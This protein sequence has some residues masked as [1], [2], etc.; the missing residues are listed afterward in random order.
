MPTREQSDDARPVEEV[1]PQV[2]S[3]EQVTDLAPARSLGVARGLCRLSD[4]GSGLYE[5]HPACIGQL[6]MTLRAIEEPRLQLP[7]EPPDL[8]TQGGLG[9]M[10]SGG[11][12]P[13][14]QLFGHREE[15]TQV[16]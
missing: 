3:H 7:L 2:T 14:V 5:E 13:E 15:V 12:T 10:E 4:E 8:L 6:H 1:D 11:R 9:D 16:P